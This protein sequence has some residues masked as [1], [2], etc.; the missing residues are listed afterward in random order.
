MTIGIEAERANLP[1]KTGVEVYAA[2]LIRHLARLDAKNQYVLYFRTQ[3]QEWFYHLGPNFKLKVIPFPK[4]WTQLRISWEMLTHAVD[5]LAILASAL[6]IWHPR[7]S[8]VTVHDVAWKLFPEAFTPFMRHYL[9][10]STRHAVKQAAKVVAVSQS[11]KNDLIKH[12]Q[13]DPQKIEVIHLA[14]GEQ[15][16]PR[17]YSDC[18]P[19]LDKFGL[20]YQKYILF[21]GTMQPRKNIP[22][23]VEAFIKIKK[24]NHMEEKLVIVGKKGWLWEPIEQKIKE[25]GL[26]QAVQVLDYVTDED[27]PFLFAGA[28]LLTLPAL[29][30]GFGLPPLEAMKSGVPV[31]VSDVSSLPEVVGDAGLLVDPNS[32]DSVAEGL[33]QVLT[34]KELRLQMI[35]KGLEQAKR[36]SWENTA[37]KTLSLF[38]SLKALNHPEARIMTSNRGS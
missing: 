19:T 33:L 11:T 28:S 17:N 35:A 13:V 9:D 8:V 4:F 31:V 26:G 27:L 24:D 2:H 7:R 37:R 12:Y 16:R 22:R 15:F 30:E 6:P 34:D 38:E 1:Q 36:F 29:Y 18:Q 25:S 14:V 5:V 10:W 3:P 21:V 32:V 23:L 20:V